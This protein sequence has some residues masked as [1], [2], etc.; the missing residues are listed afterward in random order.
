MLFCIIICG[1][2]APEVI[3]ERFASREKAE[4]RI[5]AL[6]PEPVEETESISASSMILES[7]N[8]WT[9]GI[10][11]FGE[12][13]LSAFAGE[14]RIPGITATVKIWLTMEFIYY[15]GWSSR[16]SITSISV[17]EKMGADGLIVAVTLNDAWTA[18]MQF[19]LGSG[20]S[21]QDE[22]RIIMELTSRFTGL[23]RAE[24]NISFPAIVGYSQTGY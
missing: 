21:R 11:G 20:L 7:G 2:C 19:P 18:V 3:A 15:S 13:A 9:A 4:E 10:P 17:R 1:S 16:N 14:Y 5:T 6:V 8:Y 23:S 22:D 24:Q 12:N